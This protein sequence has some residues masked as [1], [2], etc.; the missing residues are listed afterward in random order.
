M[1]SGIDL[2]SLAHALG[3]KVDF[4]IRCSANYFFWMFVFI[5]KGVTFV[6]VKSCK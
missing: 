6:I 2:L 5:K 4:L 1:R 3:K